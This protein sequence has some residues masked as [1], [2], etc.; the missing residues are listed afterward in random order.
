MG[1]RAGKGLCCGLGAAGE[2][3][4]SLTGG[5]PAPPPANVMVATAVG[6]GESGA[7]IKFSGVGTKADAADTVPA[8]ACWP[9]AEDVGC[10]GACVMGEQ[11]ALE[12]LRRGLLPRASPVDVV[13]PRRYGEPPWLP[14]DTRLEVAVSADPS[15]AAPAATLPLLKVKVLSPGVGT[16][17]LASSGGD[18]DRGDDGESDAPPERLCGNCDWPAPATMGNDAPPQLPALPKPPCVGLRA[19]ASAV[20][21]LTLPDSRALLLSE[22]T[23]A[24]EEAAPTI[25]RNDGLNSVTA[26]LADE[27]DPMM[28]IDAVEPY[29]GNILEPYGARF[30]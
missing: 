7:R 2:P 9:E 6:F 28:V 29:G 25:F 13:A 16:E 3:L 5:D 1:C 27:L 19:A 23:S 20:G 21:V 24:P 18:A 14:H 15:L 11:P 17:D 10:S 26:L 4:D 8:V 22:M 30:T 12:A